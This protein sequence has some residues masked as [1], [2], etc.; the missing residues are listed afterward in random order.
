MTA[1][2]EAG[3]REQPEGGGGTF[4]AAGAGVRVPLVIGVLM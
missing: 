3:V 4:V 1:W 2:M